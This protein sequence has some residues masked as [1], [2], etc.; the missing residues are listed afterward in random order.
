MKTILAA[1]N[2]KDKIREIKQIL[3]NTGF[4]VISLEDAGIE[5]DP[6]ESGGTFAENALIKAR[7][8]Y[9]VMKT[10]VIADDTGLSVEALNGNPGVNSRRYAGPGAS[11]ADNNRHLIENLEK[12][13]SKNFNAS[14]ICV[15][16]LIEPD[17]NE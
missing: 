1:S 3:T 11:Y 4:E 17:G 9:D 8:A 2:N 14:F 13:G 15:I 12:S 10:Y 7:A 5:I 6:D 16:S